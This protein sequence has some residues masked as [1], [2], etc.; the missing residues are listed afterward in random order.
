MPPPRILTR[1]RRIEEDSDEA[2]EI[3]TKAGDKGYNSKDRGGGGARASKTREVRIEIEEILVNKR[4]NRYFYSLFS[5]I[6]TPRTEGLLELY[7]YI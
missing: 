3:S 1:A 2:L 6:T 7:I 5:I 4:D